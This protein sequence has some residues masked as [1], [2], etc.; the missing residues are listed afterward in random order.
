MIATL[1]KQPSQNRLFTLPIELI[2]KI[3]EYDDTCKQYYEEHILCKK[4]IVYEDELNKNRH[5]FYQM[6][7]QKRRFEGKENRKKFC[8]LITCG[9]KTSWFDDA[10]CLA[11]PF[12]YDLTYIHSRHIPR[13][14]LQK[15]IYEYNGKM[16]YFVTCPMEIRE[17]VKGMYRFLGEPDGEDSDDSCPF[18]VSLYID[19]EDEVEEHSFRPMNNGTYY[20]MEE[21]V[22]YGKYKKM[23]LSGESMG[24]YSN[25]ILFADKNKQGEDVVIIQVDIDV[26]ALEDSMTETEITYSLLSDFILKKRLREIYESQ[27]Y[28][29]IQVNKEYL[30][31]VIE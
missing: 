20:Y 17:F 4:E 14:N 1:S 30:A 7:L 24:D 18:E 25:L 13:V 8:E 22:P 12:P 23:T 6:I 16:F 5:H 28:D 2:E 27:V 29:I 3:F 21:H 31:K 11:F 9:I 10:N 15:N 19:W 26:F